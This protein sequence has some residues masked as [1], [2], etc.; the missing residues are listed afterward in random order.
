MAVY[1]T[2][3]NEDRDNRRCETISIE[4]KQEV[5]TVLNNFITYFK[6]KHL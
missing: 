3:T 6:N 1:K 5:M 4:K 2:Y